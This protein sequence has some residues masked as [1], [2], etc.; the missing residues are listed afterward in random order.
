MSLVPTVTVGDRGKISYPLSTTCCR[1]NPATGGVDA[2]SAAVLRLRLLR[3][4]RRRSRRRRY[5]SDNAQH[6]QQCS[7]TMFCSSDDV[8]QQQQCSTTMFGNNVQQQRQCSTAA[9]MFSNNV[10][11]QCTTTTTA[12]ELYMMAYLPCSISCLIVH[13]VPCYVSF[14]LTTFPI[15]SSDRSFRSYVL[16]VFNRY[17]NCL[18][19]FDHTFPI[20]CFICF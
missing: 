15:T 16:Y 20:V 17:V 4:R 3:L 5:G 18:Y 7:A 12:T 9:T 13:I 6:Q 19:I 1:H 8:L 10:P 11:Q 2:P 14:N